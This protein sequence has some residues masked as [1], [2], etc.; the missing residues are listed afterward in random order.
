MA[1]LVAGVIDFT[2]VLTA[3]VRASL[4]RRL[5]SAGNRRRG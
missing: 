2:A 1:F 3:V 4:R 5:A